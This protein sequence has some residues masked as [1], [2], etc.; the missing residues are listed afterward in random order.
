MSTWTDD[1]TKQ[2]IRIRRMIRRMPWQPPSFRRLP[3]LSPKFRRLPKVFDSEIRDS[4]RLC[5]ASSL[6]CPKSLC[7]KS[8]GARRTSIGKPLNKW[9]HLA[10]AI[11]EKQSRL[12]HVCLMILNSHALS[13]SL[14]PKSRFMNEQSSNVT[15]GLAGE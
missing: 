1:D 10:M 9:R 7:L 2:G 4:F 14:V 3:R 8:G 13:T 5:P 11:L 6:T 15:Q 12:D